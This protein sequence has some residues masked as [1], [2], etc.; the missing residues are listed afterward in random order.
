MRSNE[1][2][3][4]AFLG[5]VAYDEGALREAV[6]HYDRAIAISSGQQGAMFGA[7]FRGYRAT[8]LHELGDAAAGAAYADA[9]AQARRAHSRRFEA[10]FGGW[11]AVLLAQQGR[12]DE[13]AATLDAADAMADTDEMREIFALH[14]GH[15]DLAHADVAASAGDATLAQ[16]H[17]AL[18]CRRHAAVRAEGEPALREL[19]AAHRFLERALRALSPQRG[20]ARLRVGWRAQWI[21]HDGAR[22]GL[23]RH[24][25]LRQLVWELSLRR[26]LEPGIPA[27][28]D[29]LIAAAWPDERL[30]GDSG[31]HRLRVALSTLRRLGLRDAIV[32]LGDGYVLDPGRS[33]QLALGA[34]A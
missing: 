13:A 20:P 23:A 25:A 21:E 10:L 7:I 18:A 8:A 11:R 12:L 17:E 24:R 27:A 28:V 1:A 5:S 4:S 29:A 22:I 32:T 19:R 14:R 33:L 16:R 2:S 9:L 26:I 31:A 3:A 15:L 34:E 30:R 6:R